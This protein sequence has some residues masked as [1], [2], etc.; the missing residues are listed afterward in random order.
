M[1]DLLRKDHVDQG[2]Y[3]DVAH[4]PPYPDVVEKREDCSL[5]PMRDDVEAPRTIT[6]SERMGLG[7]ESKIR[8]K[9]LPS[10]ISKIYTDLGAS[11]TECTVA[12]FIA[13]FDAPGGVVIDTLS[14]DSES[15]ITKFRMVEASECDL[16]L[17]YP[18]R[19]QHSFNK[20]EAYVLGLTK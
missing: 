10:D 5:L 4:K 19:T 18:G 11:K 1:G 20:D 14:E 3:A 15:D 8:Y 16:Y 13:F 2:E 17:L 6:R 7:Y 12:E 9:E